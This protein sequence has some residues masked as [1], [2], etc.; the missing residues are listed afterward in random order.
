MSEQYSVVAG[1]S[2]KRLSVLGALI[3]FPVLFGGVIAG[4]S[5]LA[6]ILP[7]L[8]APAGLILLVRYGTGLPTS[9]GIAVIGATSLATLQ[10]SLTNPARAPLIDTWLASSCAAVATFGLC[11]YVV[12]EYKQAKP[13][14]V[15][16][17][18][19]SMLASV[20]QFAV[21]GY[22]APD[23]ETIPIDGIIVGLSFLLVSAFFGLCHR[24]GSSLF[25]RFCFRLCFSASTTRYA[26]KCA[27]GG[28]PAQ[29]NLR[30]I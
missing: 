20:V 14:A 13:R 15:V 12:S 10:V 7:L 9:L 17:A 24:Y 6:L 8:A 1:R 21:I 28:L 3:V 30:R 22:A 19:I 29:F 18:L 5:S 16:V 27:L 23:S 4:P 25:V 26:F 11:L 2:L